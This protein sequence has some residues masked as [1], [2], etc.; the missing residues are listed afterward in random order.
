MKI[1][2]MLNAMASWLESPNNEAVLLSE[3]DDNC[4]E[5]VAS[6]C[7]EAAVALRKAATEVDKIEP[8][9]PSNLTPESLDKLADIAAAFDESG[10][11]ELQKQASVIDELLFTI[12]AP[13]NLVDK[14]KAADDSRIE[15]LKRKYEGSSD[16]LKKMNDVENSEKAI[17]ESGLT[18]QYLVLEAPLS[19]RTCPDHPGAQ[20]SRVNED[21]W[22]CSL[23]KKVYN[24][25]TG[26]TLENG[27]V[28]PG[29]DVANQT[30]PAQDSHSIFDTR[31]GRLGTNQP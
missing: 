8:I 7:V 28:V 10:D 20:I 27:A 30:Q 15:E 14:K 2:E 29:G 31:S 12:A 17:K 26:Y 16:E 4:L 19:A 6:S 5:V 21:M 3:Y 11:P 9:E 1:S 22:Q 23:D 13:V 25:R 24:Y 18:K